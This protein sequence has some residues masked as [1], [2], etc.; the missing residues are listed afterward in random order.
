M[1]NQRLADALS[2]LA[3]GWS[4]IALCPHDHEGVPNTHKIGCKSPGKAPVWP[5]KTYQERLPKESEV[6]LFW[7]RIPN[8]N[9][10]IAMGPVSGLLGIDI[11]GQAGFDLFTTLSGGEIPDT[12]EFSTPG[13]G[14]RFL[15]KWPGFDVKIK[16][17]KGPDGHEAI[18][19]LAKGS[20]TVAPPSTHEKGGAYTWCMDKGP[21]QTQLAECPPWLV[22]LL[23]AGDDQPVG[24]TSPTPAVVPQGPAKAELSPY[25]RAKI[26]LSKCDPALSESGGHSQTF[27]VA[28]KL[29]KGFG[30]N[31]DEAYELMWTHYNPTCQPPWTEKELQHKIDEA[32][33]SP[34]PV[35]FLLDAKQDSSA[36][37]LPMPAKPANI[38]AEQPIALTRSFEAIETK[39]IEWLWQKWIPLGKLAI[40]DGDPGLGKS[41]MLVDLAARISTN[42][43]MPDGSIGVSGNVLL[44]SAEDGPEDTIKPRI[45]AAGAN[46]KRI[47]DLS[48][49]KKA[50]EERPP[51]IP[52]D[53]PL[54]EKKIEELKARLLVI[55]PLMAFLYGADANKDQEI[56]R[57][58]FKLSRIAEKHRCAIICMRHLNKGGGGKAIYRGNS[59]IGVIGHA[60]TGLIVAADPD[61]DMKRVLA[62]SKCNLA[63]KPTSLSF[64]LDPIGEVCRIGW[65]GTSN[66]KAD[67]L[68]APPPTNEEKAQKEDNQKKI[69]TAMQILEEL[70][71]QG[72][73]EIKTCK[74][75]C[76]DAGLAYRTVERAAKK[77]GLIMSMDTP[78]GSPTK[79]YWS[80]TEATTPQAAP[81]QQNLYGDG[82]V[83]DPQKGIAG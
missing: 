39:P 3:R 50:G 66:H 71:D 55:D 28:C 43:V 58:L 21:D 35:G 1:Q 75:A 30:L 82:G 63:A 42:G 57:V 64:V 16:S 20:Q 74:K 22:S 19:I 36:S 44:M 24:L 9:I 72:P 48:V 26:Y 40:L 12:L 59:S 33:K 15:F 4:V 17:L 47:H 25:D 60:R 23:K 29:V 76:L 70:L 18:R 2:Y 37:I 65:C 80:L 13:G 5:W 32:E 61:D 54:I 68:V 78:T 77:L 10:G 62:V 56:R 79:Y 45:L 69:D 38:G 49:V 53:L 81:P 7:K 34:G 27:K 31:T 67:D 46:V 73:V 52:G 41:T 11:D 14:H 8:C 51:E 83:A 6:K